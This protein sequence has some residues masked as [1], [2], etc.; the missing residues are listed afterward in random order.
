MELPRGRNTISSK[1]RSETVV[2][3]MCALCLSEATIWGCSS[4]SLCYSNGALNVTSLRL[5]KK[6]KN[7]VP[8]TGESTGPSCFHVVFPAKLHSVQ[9]SNLAVEKHPPFLF[10]AHVPTNGT[11]SLQFVGSTCTICT[12]S[13]G[14]T[15][16]IHFPPVLT[17]HPA[18][19]PHVFQII[20]DAKTSQKPTNCLGTTS[21]QI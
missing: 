6:S 12:W 17:C 2:L 13:P 1:H 20:R 9:I 19:F 8:A 10:M 11:C 21:F 18:V 16:I 4:T 3:F 14:D 7:M 15:T 5:S